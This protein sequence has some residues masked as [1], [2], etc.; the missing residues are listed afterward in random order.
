MRPI[1][2][3]E[4]GV[5]YAKKLE[6]LEGL[7]DWDRPADEIERSIRA[8]MTWPGSWFEVQG[9]RIKILSAQVENINGVPGTVIDN[10]PTVACGAG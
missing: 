5:S 4:E 2:Q 3:P 8:F 1:K 6:R 7:I 10:K 9:E